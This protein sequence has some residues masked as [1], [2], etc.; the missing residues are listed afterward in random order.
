MQARLEGKGTALIAFF[1][2]LPGI[3][4][5]MAVALGFMRANKAIVAIFMF[6]GKGLRYVVEMVLLHYGVQWINMG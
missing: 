4:D 3:G 2:W 6:I 5:L 1:S